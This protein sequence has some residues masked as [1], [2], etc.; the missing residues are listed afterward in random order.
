[1]LV[2]APAGYGKTT[3]LALWRERDQRPFA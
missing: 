2:S 1:V 3:L